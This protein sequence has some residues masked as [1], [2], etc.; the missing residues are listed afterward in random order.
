MTGEMNYINQNGIDSNGEVWGL[1]AALAEACGGELKPF[2]SY[3]GPY[4]SITGTSAK[5]WLVED[6][7]D[8]SGYAHVYREDTEEYADFD[9]S[10]TESAICAARSL[11]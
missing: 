1:H 7:Q 6:N 10:D 2:D 4:I 8:L 11:L 3:Q 9:L 5:L